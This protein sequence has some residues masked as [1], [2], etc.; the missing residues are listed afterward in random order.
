MTLSTISFCRLVE[1]V[2]RTRMA[3]IKSA[4][5]LKILLL[6]SSFTPELSWWAG[7]SFLNLPYSSSEAAELSAISMSTTALSSSCPRSRLLGLSSWPSWRM[8]GRASISSWAVPLEV[9]S[10]PA[11]LPWA[12]EPG[13]HT[14]CLCQPGCQQDHR[15][16]SWGWNPGPDGRSGSYNMEKC[17][18]AG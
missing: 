8:A 2:T 3:F 4:Q 1:A 16:P 17:E 14:P 6:T 11:P 12:P 7:S 15:V 5:E 10:G 18:W 9:L 13:P